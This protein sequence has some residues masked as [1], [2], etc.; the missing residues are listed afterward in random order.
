MQSLQSQELTLRTH[1][2]I[3]LAVPQLDK[4]NAEDLSGLEQILFYC[5]LQQIPPKRVVPEIEQFLTSNTMPLQTR[6][7]P[8]QL[9]LLGQRRPWRRRLLEIA[10]KLN[11]E[12]TEL[13]RKRQASI[14]GIEVAK[15]LSQRSDIYQELGDLAKAIEMKKKALDVFNQHDLFDDAVIAL[16]GLCQL[17]LAQNTTEGYVEAFSVTNQLI[18]R[19]E[20]QM[21]GL[22]GQSVP[23]FFKKYESI[24]MRT[25]ALTLNLYQKAVEKKSPHSSAT[26]ESFLLIAD[27]M[28]F[29]PVRRDFAIYQELGSEVGAHPETLRHFEAQKQKIVS[30]REER[31][32]AKENGKVPAD[33]RKVDGL[34]VDSPFESLK[35]AHQELISILEDFKRLKVGSA[36]TSVGLPTSLAVVR[37]GM[38]SSDGIVMYVQAPWAQDEDGLMAAVLTSSQPPRLIML[39]D[40]TL[41]SLR[42]LVGEMLEQFDLESPEAQQTLA[43][44]AAALWLPLGQLPDNLTV[45]LTPGLIGIPFESLPTATGKPVIASHKVRYAFGLAPGMGAFD[46]KAE[47]RRA[48]IAGASSFKD[49]PAL[50]SSKAEVESLRGRLRTLTIDPQEALPSAGLPLFKQRMDYDFIHLSTHSRL[51]SDVPMADSLAFPTDDL[52][53][54]DLAISPV[55]ANLLVLSSCELFRQRRDNFNPVSGITTAAMARVAPQVVSTLWPVNSVATQ[56]FMLRF[57]DA[58]LTEREPAAA[59]AVAK[60]SFLEPARL[61]EWLKS[62]SISAPIGIRSYKEPY[63]WAPFVLTIG[64]AEAGR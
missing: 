21:R 39:P 24:Y 47:Y 36:E 28:N 38:T 18:M 22:V 51:D 34:I 25:F 13:D 10:L 44:I 45:V 57:Y 9:V 60:R 27:R 8:E 63:Y 1:L 42:A 64:I 52:F 6:L 23:S 35:S 41:K 29:R 5:A 59:L 54:Y 48:L 58:L 16:D 7:T 2:Y 12:V 40:M 30:L 26:L 49:L 4:L 20:R 50:P 19:I 46:R 62:A 15:D 33:Y 14:A 3:R 17:Y 37:Q 61:E 55:R 53:A 56:I 31:E 43:K 32:R 11:E